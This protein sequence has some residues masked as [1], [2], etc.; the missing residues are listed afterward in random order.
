LNRS[1]EN[2]QPRITTTNIS[3]PFEKWKTFAK[4]HQLVDMTA[5][6]EKDGFVYIWVSSINDPNL[7]WVQPYT[8]D[9]LGIQFDGMNDLYDSNNSKGFKISVGMMV[10]APF[11]DSNVYLRAIVL[12][13]L[14]NNRSHVLFVDYGNDIE[15]DNLLLK[16]MSDDYNK[17]P[18][19]AV[20]CSLDCLKPIQGRQ[21]SDKAI[22][23]FSRLTNAGVVLPSKIKI[24]NTLKWGFIY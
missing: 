2:G 6:I 7:F 23:L 11:K 24:L 17:K 15:I 14:S 9:T 12:N 20:P 13:C 5:L 3:K 16:I 10:A 1:P 18:W 22:S 21:W 19:Q 8:L 4:L